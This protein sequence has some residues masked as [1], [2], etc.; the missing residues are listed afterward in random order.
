MKSI[1]TLQSYYGLVVIILNVFLILFLSPVTRFHLIMMLL[2]HI[3][4]TAHYASLRPRSCFSTGSRFAVFRATKG[5]RLSCVSSAYVLKSDM[6]CSFPVDAVAIEE[7]LG[8]YIY[9]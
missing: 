8:W 4:L 3:A 7:L 9:P 6:E 2:S 5:Y 1:L